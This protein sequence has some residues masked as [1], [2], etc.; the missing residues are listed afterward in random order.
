MKKIAVVAGSFDPFTKGH[1]W[2]VSEALKT[3][4]HVQVVIGNNMAKSYMFSVDER[5]HMICVGLAQA[6]VNP[7]KFSCHSLEEG[8]LVDYALK[9]LAAEDR[10]AQITL[11]RGIRDSKDFEY[12]RDMLRVNRM[13]VGDEPKINTVFV[14]PPDQYLGISSSAVKT[15]VKHG[16]SDR[17]IEN[18]VSSFVADKIRER[19]GATA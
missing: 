18:F 6:C 10:L 11:F 5:K 4:Q 15:L 13:I 9:A 1:A 16:A 7:H 17:V 8:L 3:H 14:I 2:L 12:E 19:L